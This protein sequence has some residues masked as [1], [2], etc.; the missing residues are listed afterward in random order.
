MGMMGKTIDSI[1]QKQAVER[2]SAR[3]LS[4]KDR[5]WCYYELDQMVG[6]FAAGLVRMGL[7][8]NDRVA[9]YLP[10]QLETVAALFGSSRAGGVFVPVNPGLKAA[11]V[12][13][14]AEHSDA[15]FMVTSLQ[16]AQMMLD[17]LAA[18]KD[19]EFLILT[20]IDNEAALEKLAMVKQEVILWQDMTAQK[21]NHALTVIRRSADLAALM[22]TSGSTGMPKGVM[23]T[24]QNLLVGAESVSSYLENTSDDHILAV[25]P[26]SFDYGLSQLTTAFF[27]GAAVRLINHL[28]AKD[29]LTEIA[30]E[31]ITGLA[32]VP[33]LWM[34]LLTLNWPEGAVGVLRYGTNSGGHMPHDQI[35]LFQEKAGCPSF[36]AMYGLTEAFRSTYLPPEMTD[37]KEGSM[38]K[39]IPHADV[40][41][42]KEDGTICA[43]GEVGELVHGGPL[44]AQGYWRDQVK[45]DKRFRPLKVG[46]A[47]K[48]VW[49]GDKAYCD[50]EG[51]FYFVGR[52]D[53]MIKTSGYRVSPMEVERVI[54]AFA[55]VTEVVA[56]G[57]PDT[58]LGQKIIAHMVMP[59]DEL[60]ALK[61]YLRI[62]LPTYMVPHDLI[63]TEQLAKN[64]NGKIDRAGIRQA[65]LA[66]LE[67]GSGV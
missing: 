41:I 50:E 26:F 11:Q 55:A 52:D 1:I 17:D 22:Y 36:F 30:K 61:K 24:H 9:V 64:P 21:D 38:G 65:Y 49:S 16:R 4:Y 60:T 23:V 48:W 46:E 8:P 66:G 12:R 51:Y 63:V 40:R 42:V 33:P 20:D 57:V 43:A 67:N 19:L 39:A 58:A 37:H 28:F 10:K 3:A 32:A 13:Y 47:E 15:R 7:R 29:I 18:L 62:Q 25:L 27:R 45:T 56:Y 53:E 54:L 59:A 2:P 14:I 34:E 6:S 35:K 31:G 44:V 5:N